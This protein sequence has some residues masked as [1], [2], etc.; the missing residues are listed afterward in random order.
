MR[1]RRVGWDNNEN[2]KEGGI[3]RHQNNIKQGVKRDS[4]EL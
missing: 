3:K 2:D 1:K 4:S